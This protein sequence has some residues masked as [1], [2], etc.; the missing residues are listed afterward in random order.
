MISLT[1]KGD[2]REFYETSA[3]PAQGPV[4]IEASR[5]KQPA[6]FCTQKGP[7]KGSHTVQITDSSRQVDQ[8]Q[9]QAAFDKGLESL[10][11]HLIHRNMYKEAVKMGRQTPNERTREF[12]RRRAR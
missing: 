1:T 12:S 5:G 3:D 11:I 2:L 7:D 4:L 6:S 10:H 8:G 9:S